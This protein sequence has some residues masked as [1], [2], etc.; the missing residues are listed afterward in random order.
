MMARMVVPVTVIVPSK[1]RCIGC[2]YALCGNTS[3]RC[4]ECGREFDPAD[5]TT[6]DMGS[7][8]RALKTVEWMRV[9]LKLEIAFLV[10]AFLA[11]TSH[12]DQVAIWAGLG[13]LIA[14]AATLCLQT[15]AD[16]LLLGK[17]EA[18]RYL[19]AAL[20]LVP[21]YFIG[22]ILVPRLVEIEVRRRVR[23][24]EKPDSL[25]QHRAAM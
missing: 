22:P 4:P 3:V 24:V 5:A 12:F 15:Y 13:M 23:E 1:A 20:F 14:A 7:S 16:T 18:R 6:F 11:G 17:D 2:G 21:F 8:R 10:T 9:C 19:L 25:P